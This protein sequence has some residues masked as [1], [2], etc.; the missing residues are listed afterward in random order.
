MVIFHILLYLMDLN[1]KASIIR[2]P[3]TS[4]L[5]SDGP[6]SLL[7][8]NYTFLHILLRSSVEGLT[9]HYSGLLLVYWPPDCG[10]TT[11]I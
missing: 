9:G 7:S 2:L 1:I 8:S 10:G 11:G 4:K 3:F 6:G 5:R